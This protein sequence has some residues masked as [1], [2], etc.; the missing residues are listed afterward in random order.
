MVSAE[1]LEAPPRKLHRWHEVVL[2]DD[3]PRVLG[4]MRRL[5]RYEPY[6]LVTT[7]QPET[8]LRWADE[9]DIS[10]L[11]TDE[12][13]PGMEGHQL[14]QEC[15]KRSPSL[16]CMVLTAYP[17]SALAVPGLREELAAVVTK[18]WDDEMI[19]RTILQILREKEAEEPWEMPGAE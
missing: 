16:A 10:L 8:A 3:E 6:D 2:V 14:V 15:R 12:R 13:M 18:P 1:L 5:L 7:T 4:A 17:E 19:R 11:I 9:R